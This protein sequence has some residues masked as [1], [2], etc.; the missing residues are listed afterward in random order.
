S[1]ASAAS[2][3]PPEVQQSRQLGFGRLFNLSERHDAYTAGLQQGIGSNLRLDVSYW[4]RQV[5]NAADQ[6]QFFNT[7]IVFPLNFKGG[8][9]SPSTLKGRAP[10]GGSA[11]LDFGPAAGVRGYLS[12]GP[13]RAIYAPPFVGGLFLDV[14]ALDTLTSG[15]FVIDHDQDLQE[16][17]GLYWDIPR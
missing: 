13:V 17:L 3:V 2:L 16:Q 15:P 9:V 6:D 12:G 8:L 4:K 10:S 1:S 7:G 11:R 5:D 14:G